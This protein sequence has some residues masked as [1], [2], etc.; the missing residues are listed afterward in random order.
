[1]IQKKLQSIQQTLS[2]YLATLSERTTA[3]GSVHDDSVKERQG[4]YAIVEDV[5]SSI[6][7]LL[8]ISGAGLRDSLSR[9]ADELVLLVEENL[10]A[11]RVLLSSSVE[12]RSACRN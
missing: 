9:S 3:L 5:R 4:F 6:Q 8:K 10:L 2:T 1:M 12:R 7:S 11:V